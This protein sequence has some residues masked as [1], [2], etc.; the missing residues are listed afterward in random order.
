VY[1]KESGPVP[2]G[3]ELGI[4]ITCPQIRHT[5]GRGGSKDSIADRTPIFWSSH[6]TDSAIPSTSRLMLSER[7][8]RKCTDR[9]IL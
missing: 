5:F 9:R 1:M 7:C 8:S 4:F 2:L 3:K 6:V